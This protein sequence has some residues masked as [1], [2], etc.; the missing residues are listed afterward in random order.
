MPGDE[1]LPLGGD[2]NDDLECGTGLCCFQ[3]DSVDDPLAVPADCP[4]GVPL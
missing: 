3:R 4:P 1:P 2:C